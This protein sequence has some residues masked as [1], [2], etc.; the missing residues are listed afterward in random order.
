MSFKV[1]YL[2]EEELKLLVQKRPVAF[3]QHEQRVPWSEEF[4]K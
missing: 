3:W 4:P 1:L 2:D